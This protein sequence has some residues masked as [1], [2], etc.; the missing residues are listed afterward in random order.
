MN[1]SERHTITAKQGAVSPEQRIAKARAEYKRESARLMIFLHL[2]VLFF[3]AAVALWV[4]SHGWFGAVFTD[5]HPASDSR[6]FFVM[7]MWNVLMYLMPAMFAALSAGCLAV[8]LVFESLGLF[9]LYTTLLWQK[10]CMYRQS[11]LHRED[12]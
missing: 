12:A 10:C 11:R 1:K 3:V 5:S 6:M 2:T 4:V 9:S 7:T 8:A